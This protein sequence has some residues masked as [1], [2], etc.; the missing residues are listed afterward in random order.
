VCDAYRRRSQS[1]FVAWLGGFSVFTI[2]VNNR[3][4]AEDFDDD[5]RCVRKRSVCAHFTRS[6]DLRTVMK[7]AGCEGEKICFI[8]DESNVL[9]SAFL[10][11]MNTL[12]AGGDVPGLFEGEEFTALMHA[13]RQ[14]AQRAG[15]LIDADDELYRYFV[16]QV[17]VGGAAGVCAR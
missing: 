3:Y 11:R 1:R 5:L 7:R 8:F 15:Q 2:K 9:S 13:C 10:E 6:R 14:S 16:K 12:L 17:S 4:S